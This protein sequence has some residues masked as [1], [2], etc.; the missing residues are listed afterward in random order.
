MPFNSF[1][2][3]STQRRLEGPKPPTQDDTEERQQ[4]RNRK[5][6]HGSVLRKKTDAG[7]TINSAVVDAEG[8]SAISPFSSPPKESDLTEVNLQPIAHAIHSDQRQS[9]S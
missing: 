6:D 3:S 8:L 1:F 2:G 5:Q 7:K 9:L 4:S